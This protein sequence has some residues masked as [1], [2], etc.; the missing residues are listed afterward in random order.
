MLGIL[1]A[2]VAAFVI[3]LGFYSLVPAGGDGAAAGGGDGGE[4]GRGDGGEAGG[5]ERGEA[6]GGA[7]AKPEA[8]RIGVELLRS[9]LTAALVTGLL[10]AA[11][12]DGAATGALLGLA[13]W[14]LP[15][16]LLAGSVIWERVPPRRAAPHAVDW[17]LKLVAIGAIAG[18]F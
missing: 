3:S 16:V 5:G 6:G 7:T 17:L 8:W 1:V 2:T 18:A 12:W 15:V 10:R 9:A 14:T 11:E 4:A 13:L